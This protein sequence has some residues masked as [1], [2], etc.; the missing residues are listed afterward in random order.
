M[1]RNGAQRTS[2]LPLQLLLITV[3]L[4]ACGQELVDDGHT[5][6]TQ[7][8]IMSVPVERSSETPLRTI[9]EQYAEF[10]G[11]Y[12]EEGDLV[13]TFTPSASTSTVSNA[14]ALISSQE[15]KR[16]CRR[17]DTAAHDPQIVVKPVTYSFLQMA[18]WRDALTERLF[19][20][21]TAR[22]IGIDYASN[23]LIATVSTGGL[24]SAGDE[25]AALS[26]PVGAIDI[27]EA[28]PV[29][30]TSGTACPNPSPEFGT[31]S[32]YELVYCFR[33]TP[34]G[35]KIAMGDNGDVNDL[36]AACTITS[37][38]SLWLTSSNSYQPG[39]VTASHCLAPEL[40]NNGDWV[41]QPN[42]GSAELIATEYV[43]PPG[44]PCGSLMC[45]YSD[46]S[47]MWSVSPDTPQVGAIAQTLSWNGVPNTTTPPN[48]SCATA[49]APCTVNSSYPHFQIAGSESPVQG[50]Q[51]EKVGENSGW[52]T[53]VVTGTCTDLADNNGRKFV[54]NATATN[55]CG[56][57]DSGSPV[58]YWT[59]DA[60]DSVYMIGLLWGEGTPGTSDYSMF[61]PWSNVV[62]DLGTMDITYRSIFDQ[63]SAGAGVRAIVGDY[64]GDH[65]SDIAL[66]G[67]TGW[68]TVPVALSNGNGTFTLANTA[69]TSFAGYSSTAGAQVVAADINNDGYDDL[70]AVGGAGWTYIPVAVSS[71]F[72]GGVGSFTVTTGGNA[73]LSAQAQNSGVKV[74]GE[75]VNGDSKDDIVIVG[76]TGV[77]G[78]WVGTSNGD[79]TFAASFSSASTFASWAQGTGV[80]ALAGDFNHDGYADIALTG[81]SGWATV[82]VAFRQS[83]GQY[84]VTNN[85]VSSFPSWAQ[86]SGAKAVAGD[87]NGDLKT[88]LALT[89]GPGWTTVPAALSNGD[90]TFTV[91]NNSSPTFG[92]NAQTSGVKPIAG[93][94]DNNGHADVS[95]VG[96]PQWWTI[97]ISFTGSTGAYTYSNRVSP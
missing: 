2:T 29:R 52:T 97:P 14:V 49:G 76:G 64:N 24:Q 4:A 1:L 81:G 31:S 5:S 3:V 40:V 78:I 96:V 83:N 22:S 95:L 48:G 61:S 18:A 66:V 63:K 79:G 41:N 27:S 90:G 17:R 44:W 35:V 91:T 54:C 75:D 67:G 57:G 21:P 42:F 33:T 8:P 12:C 34:A 51:V 45:K 19:E 16:L 55:P 65:R 84:S 73:I 80:T 43:D 11:Y 69:S 10:G 60:Y 77:T 71:G 23:R 70:V 26:I 59:L 15:T 39:F 68:T 58:F 28:A 53:G 94:F 20:L 74:L 56:P 6:S 89:G 85:S 86:N 38:N 46:S 13:V 82:P 72:I 50:M 62:Q 93:D 37:A 88:D 87:F 47:W 32:P 36:L 30:K 25:V 9:A 92:G 7:S